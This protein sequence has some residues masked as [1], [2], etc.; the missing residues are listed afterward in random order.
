[1]SIA[2]W[3]VDSHLGGC[4]SCGCAACA[5]VLNYAAGQLLYARATRGDPLADPITLCVTEAHAHLGH[6]VEYHQQPVGILCLFF[7]HPYQFT[8]ADRRLLGIFA[9]A[10]SGEENRKRT[11]AELRASDERYRQ[12]VQTANE[13]IWVTDEQDQ[14]TFANHRLARMLGYTPEELMQRA[15]RDFI[16]PAEVCGSRISTASR[17]PGAAQ[18]VRAPAPAQGRAGALGLG[19]RRRRSSTTTASTGAALPCLPM[20]PSAAILKP[21]CG[22]CKNSNP[23]ASSPGAS[24]TISIIFWPPS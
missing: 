1:M 5:E 24:R 17:P 8:D 15:A 14:I 2:Q 18:P 10:L 22:R 12:I 3:H 20:S 7:N 11:D 6:V 4:V 16:D 23:S 13:G 9:A 19:L 21:N